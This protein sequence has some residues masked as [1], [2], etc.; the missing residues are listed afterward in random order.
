MASQKIA[1]KRAE[2]RRALDASLERIVALLSRRPEVQRVILFGS[3]AEGRADLLTDLD[4]LVVMESPLDFVART[5][6]LYRELDSAVDVDLLVYT[7]EEFERHRQHGFLRRILAKGKVLY[8]KT[9]SG[10]GSA[11]APAGR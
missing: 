5:A 2:Y 7:P 1:A 3:Y 6:A 11:L 4:L 9:A 10:G 8:E